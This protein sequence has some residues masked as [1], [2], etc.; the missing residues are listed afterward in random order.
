MTSDQQAIGVIGLGM[1]GA[2]AAAAYLAAGRDV[3]GFDIAATA[4]GEAGETGV[5]IVDG[6]AQVAN[7][8]SVVLLSLPEPSDV[9]SVAAELAPA[10]DGLLVADHSTIDPETA[11]AAAQRI[12]AG[13]GRYVDAPVLGRPA[14]A[15]TWTL[16]AG[17]RP[18]DVDALRAVA[19]GSVAKAVVHVGD[20]GAG[21]VVKLLNNMMF[22]AINTITA[23]VLDLAERWGL[24]PALF[25]DVVADSGA[26]T[27]SPLFRDVAPRMASGDHTTVFS[28]ALLLKDVRLGLE[29]ARQLGAA[30]EVSS[31]VEAVTALAAELGHAQDDTSSVIEVY[32]A[33]RS[34]EAKIR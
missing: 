26:A 34:P 8:A 23:E 17:G 25:P 1:M 10:A 31:A 4:R 6:P 28:V 12:A 18:A 24:P 27:T 13:G 33:R 22:G 11:R 7:E 2:R 16:P 15:G 14:N 20:V 19:V 3:V 9:L 32:R 30:A 21:S 29:L 5:R